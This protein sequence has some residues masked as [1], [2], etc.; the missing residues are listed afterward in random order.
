MVL[1]H[2]G[3]LAL[4]AGSVAAQSRTAALFPDCE[5]GPLANN[6]ICDTNA[7]VADR[8][9]ALVAELTV[10]EKFNLTGNTSPGVPR[11]GLPAYQWW[12]EYR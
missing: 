11:L 7:S 10:E 4:L 12:R 5:N 1:M 2:I 9:R 3:L 8:A 6:T